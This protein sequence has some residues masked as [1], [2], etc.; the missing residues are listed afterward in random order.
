M[1]GTRRPIRLT[2]AQ[3]PHEKGPRRGEALFRF[4]RQSESALCTES[5]ESGVAGD[6]GETGDGADP[7]G[8][9]V[10]VVCVCVASGEDTAETCSAGV[11]VECAL[12][13]LVEFGVAGEACSPAVGAV[14]AIAPDSR[15]P[16]GAVPSAPVIAPS[17]M[18]SPDAVRRSSAFA[19]ATAPPP[20]TA[21]PSAPVTP[22]AIHF[23]LI[24][25]V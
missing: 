16:A 8:G 9:C 12:C 21:T 19:A 3:E 22:Y 13:P 4:A 20:S 17:A 14:R 23:L 15:S 2:D 11:F 6:A 1:R 5:G 25:P 24:C 18:T 10:V 7:A